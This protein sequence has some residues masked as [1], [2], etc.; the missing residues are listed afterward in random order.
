[1]SERRLHFLIPTY[2]PYGGV[3]KVF[4]YIKHARALGYGARVWCREPF[5]PSLRI[6]HNDQFRPLLDDP[7][8]TFHSRKRLGLTD[9]DLM[10]ISLPREYRRAYQRLRPT[11]SPERIIHIIQNVRHVNTAWTGGQATRVLTRPAARIS[12]NRVVA[13]TIQPWLDPRGLHRVINLGHANEHFRLDRSGG[14][15]DGQRPIRVAYT[16][17]KSPVGDLVELALA[18]DPRFTFRAIR[19]T[20][21]WVE[22]REL[23]Q[24]ADVFLSTPLAEEGM[25]LPGLEA[26]AAGALVVT[27]DAGGNMAYCR[28]EENC[29]L[30][31]FGEPASYA[32]ALR[33]LADMTVPQ[34]ESLRNAAYAM[35]HEFDL[36]HER[37]GFADFLAELWPRIEA[38][39]SVR[40][41]ALEPE[42]AAAP[43]ADV[44]ADLPADIAIDPPVDVIDEL[45]LAGEVRR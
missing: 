23:Y 16:T 29:L 11:W 36:D 19:Q 26:M 44:P 15:G 39:E 33:R 8:V 3:V 40:R 25:Y 30:V 41:A 35:T 4:D 5:D 20:A 9:S 6:F 10:F 7:E 24:W 37:A 13:D 45:P 34:V 42:A 21:T 28:P 38:F 43:S 2:E 14:L 31:D 17:W 1:M 18:G 22:L 27:P 12:I 32:A